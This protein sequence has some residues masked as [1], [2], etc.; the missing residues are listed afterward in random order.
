M[1]RER[2]IALRNGKL[3]TQQQLADQLGLTRAAIAHYETGRREPDI[4]TLL[5]LSGFFGV[6]VDFLLGNSNEI[7]PPSGSGLNIKHIKLV[8]KWER[9]GLD[10][11]RVM[12]AA[13]MFAE[14]LRKANK[15]K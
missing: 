14:E 3:L 15:S 13:N 11:E 1:F 5:A 10:V 6:T 7:E 4:E 12:K 8:E 2:L 9:E